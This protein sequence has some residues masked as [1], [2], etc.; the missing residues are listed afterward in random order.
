MRPAVLSV[1]S[2]YLRAIFQ[3]SHLIKSCFLRESKSR[4]SRRA[5]VADQ[6]A[7]KRKTMREGEKA[8]GGIEKTKE[9]WD[10]VSFLPQIGHQPEVLDA[11]LLKEEALDDEYVY[12]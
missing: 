5:D 4:F 3:Q 10:S 9:Y 11:V 6:V 1:I 2:K 12:C 7:C 8:P